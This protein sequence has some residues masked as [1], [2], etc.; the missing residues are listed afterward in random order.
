MKIF[1]RLAQLAR[2]SRLHRE[3]RGF[4]PLSAHQEKYLVR[5]D[6][7]F[8]L[9]WRRARISD[10]REEREGGEDCRWQFAKEPAG[11]AALAARSSGAAERGR[12][13]LGNP[14]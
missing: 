11:Q 13:H 9:A 4:E 7:V 2:A 3:G 6:G 1:G 12:A 14:M 5:K 10:P 8:F